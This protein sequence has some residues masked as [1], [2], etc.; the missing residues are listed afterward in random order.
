MNVILLRQLLSPLGGREVSQRSHIFMLV[1][2]TFAP[3]RGFLAFSS[4]VQIGMA[5]KAHSAQQVQ[6]CM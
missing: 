6:C 3:P 1:L 5:T 2:S 4:M